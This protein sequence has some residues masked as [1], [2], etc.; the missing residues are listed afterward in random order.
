MGP[1]KNVFVSHIHEDDAG[2]GDLKGI[3]NSNGLTIRDY[4][5]NSSNPNSA[6]DEQ[7]IKYQIL[8][9]RIAAC[10]VMVVYIT[11]ET[12]HSAYVQWEIEYA[13]KCGLRIV[14]VWA[15][16]D[17]GC[18]VPPALAAVGDAVVGWHGTSIV[19]AINGTNAFE[20]PDGTPWARRDIARAEC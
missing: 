3:L 14:G 17:K 1:G 18:E 2:L 10:S 19:S 8:A 4:S 13:R 9:P 11:P 7:Y 12:R 16:G 20:R 15:H 5:I 6:E